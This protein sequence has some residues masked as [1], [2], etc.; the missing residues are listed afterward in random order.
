MPTKASD[1]V[2][3]IDSHSLHALR[4]GAAPQFEHYLRNIVVA[5]L[6]RHWLKLK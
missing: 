1:P 4:L 2:Y 5:E 3:A 6:L